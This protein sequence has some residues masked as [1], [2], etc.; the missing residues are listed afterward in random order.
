LAAGIAASFAGQLADKYSAP[1]LSGAGLG[2]LALGLVSLGLMPSETTFAIAGLMAICGLGFGFFQSPNNR[3]MLSSAPM[4]RT[5]AAGGMLA[6]ARLTGQTIGA[7]IA[8]IALHFAAHAE[9]VALVVAAAF[10]FAGALASLSR[11]RLRDPANKS[12]EEPIPDA[13]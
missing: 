7:T 2:V 8:A 5:G 10:A 1:I 13:P 12:E 11:L 6:T 9:T 4:H 3:T